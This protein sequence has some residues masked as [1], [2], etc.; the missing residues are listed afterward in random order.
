MGI[1]AGFDMVPRLSENTKDSGDWDRF[2]SIIKKEYKDDGKV[3]AT[4]SYIIFK[5]G[6]HPMLPVEGHKFLRFSSKISGRTAETTGVSA[7]ISNV[8]RIAKEQFGHRIQYWD[9]SV[10]QHGYY[11]WQD[12]HQSIRSYEK[13]RSAFLLP[14]GFF[15]H[16]SLWLTLLNL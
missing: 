6:E 9:E 13:V 14:L 15:P 3:E 2:M 16:S 4:S 7:Y 11:D 10:E 1:D 8:T 12:V 5:A